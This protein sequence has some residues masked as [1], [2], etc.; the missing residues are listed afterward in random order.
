MRKPRWLKCWILWSAAMARIVQGGLPNQ[1]QIQMNKRG[2][3][4]RDIR[5][6]DRAKTGALFAVVVGTTLL[7]G[8][9]VNTDSSEEATSVADQAVQCDQPLPLPEQPE[10]TEYAFFNHQVFTFTF[11]GFDS[12]QAETFFIWNLGTTIQHGAPYP[13]NKHDKM[14][15]IIAPGPPG[16]THHVEGQPDFDHYHLINKGAGTRTFDVFLVFQG[17]NFDLATWVPPLNEQE[18]N[19]A[20]AAGKLGPVTLTTAVVGEPLVIKEKIKKFD[21]HHH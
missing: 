11:P 14:W 13:S 4:M 6:R 7:G 1:A 9:A 21:S 19:A 15:G 17:P 18:L 16:G 3:R 8:C 2:M 10:D 5:I 12:P 20:I